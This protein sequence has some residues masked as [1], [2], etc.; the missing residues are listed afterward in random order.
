MFNQQQKPAFKFVIRS[1][2]DDQTIEEK[3]EPASIHKPAVNEILKEPEERKRK[4][5][6]KDALPPIAAKKIH[7][8]LERWNRKQEELK[9]ERE[10]EEE[11][12][13]GRNNY[14]DI[15]TLVCVLCQRK[16]KSKPDLEKHQAVSELHKKN[17]DDTSAV[18]KAKLKIGF[19]KSEQ[20]LQMKIPEPIT[21]YRN[22]AAE[23]RQ[24]Y[25]QPEKPIL[26]PPPPPPRQLSTPHA[27]EALPKASMNIP[28]SENNKGAR[29]LLQMGWKKGEG[30]G[31]HGT[32]ILDPIKAE[33]YAQS[34]GIGSTDNRRNLPRKKLLGD[35]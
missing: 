2:I 12:E 17:L 34:A 30:L 35:R 27:I 28:I 33:S 15:V 6:E 25:G 10:T 8:Q 31:K 13:R 23:R 18:N 32:G 5:A 4:R 1:K 21:E 16:F 26:S 29:M 22:R 20:D 19:M 7:S 9:Q 3:Q 14:I 24:A 11:I